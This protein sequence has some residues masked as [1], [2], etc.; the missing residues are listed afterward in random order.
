MNETSLADTD[1]VTP[2]ASA[3]PD[4]AYSLA[5]RCR[6]LLAAGDIDGAREAAENALFLVEAITHDEVAA[7]AARAV[8]DA[9]VALR[10]LDGA[11]RAEA[12][13]P[14]GRLPPLAGLRRPFGE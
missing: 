3:A 14:A 10:D 1:R 4:V 13:L 6:E 7:S 8:A 12:R 2:F 9:F 5:S 11:R